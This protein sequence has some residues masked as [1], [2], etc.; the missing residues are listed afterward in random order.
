MKFDTDTEINDCDPLTDP[1]VQP[2]VLYFGLWSNIY[3]T[4]DIPTSLSDLCSFMYV[5]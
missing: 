2:A 5:F 3:K 4:N 1:L